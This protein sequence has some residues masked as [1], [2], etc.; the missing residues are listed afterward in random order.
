MQDSFGAITSELFELTVHGLFNIS[1][2]NESEI[3]RL[4][5]NE[6]KSFNFSLDYPIDLTN[7]SYK[8]YLDGI[9]SFYDNGTLNFNYTNFSLRNNGS[10]LYNQSND[11]NFSFVIKPNFSDEGYGNLTNVSL[12]IL[13]NNFPRLKLFF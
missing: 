3:F 2:P 6:N 11:G 9:E 12:F 13:N 8:F 1:Y 4:K 10:F 7:F 5:E